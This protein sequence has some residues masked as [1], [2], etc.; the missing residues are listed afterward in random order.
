MT[1]NTGKIDAALA[2]LRQNVAR[3]LHPYVLAV[4]LVGEEDQKQII[5]GVM[6]SVCEILGRYLAT[7]E[8]AGVLVE[9]TSIEAAV[10]AF[11]TEHLTALATRE[12]ELRE[13]HGVR[14]D[15]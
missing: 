10:D 14:A 15:A 4:Q 9:G 6:N 7:L 12:K 11:K 13:E 8:F 2:G 3:E 5:A 1:E